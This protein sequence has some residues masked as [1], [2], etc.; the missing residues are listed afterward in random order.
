[1][2]IYVTIYKITEVFEETQHDPTPNQEASKNYNE[3]EQ[4][5][6]YILTKLGY[7]I[8]YDFPIYEGDVGKY[9]L[10]DGEG[11]HN[12]LNNTQII[13][14]FLAQEIK[15]SFGKI[16]DNVV[17]KELYKKIKEKIRKD[18][19]KKNRRWGAYDSGRLVREY[20][21]KGGK[22]RGSKSKTPLDRWYKE[23]WIDACVWPKKKSCGRTKAS[24]KSKV[25]YC[26]PSKVVDSK[27]P[28]TVQ[29]LT[30]KQIKN[31]CSRK[32]RNPKKIIK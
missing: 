4:L 31:R 32:K 5:L 18:V 19:D 2:L 25:T 21:S 26:R 14:D 17:N 9:N 16:P 24:I 11:V 13:N 15:N 10:L 27:T 1:M 12:F 22:Y 6:G 8:D 29:E 3:S 7:N 28:K 30:K 20:K 23:K